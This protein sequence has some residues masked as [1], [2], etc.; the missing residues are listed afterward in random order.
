MRASVAQGHIATLFVTASFSAVASVCVA[1]DY[2]MA[3]SLHS[4][5]FQCNIQCFPRAVMGSK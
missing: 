1:I 2:S 5:F 3:C 4:V